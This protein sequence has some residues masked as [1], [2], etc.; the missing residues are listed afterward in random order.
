MDR[1]T[2]RMLPGIYGALVLIGFLI[3]AT[4]GVIVC[5]GG[6]A[7]FG[8]LWAAAGGPRDPARGPRQRSRLR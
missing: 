7:P 6:G 5:A 8:A 2:R 3:S 4:V 1:R